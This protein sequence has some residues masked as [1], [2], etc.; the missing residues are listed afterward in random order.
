MTASVEGATTAPT[1]DV[2]DDTAGN[3][4]D[5]DAPGDGKRV[6]QR[7]AFGNRNRYGLSSAIFYECGQ[8]SKFSVD[9]LKRLII[10]IKGGAVI[11]NICFPKT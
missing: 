4:A 2:E 5:G 3:V 8:L 10:I 7:W 11:L 1:A 6:G 9:R